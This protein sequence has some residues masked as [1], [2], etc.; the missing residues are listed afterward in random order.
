MI[1]IADCEGD[2]CRRYD[3]G[4]K[5]KQKL[6]MDG[7]GQQQYYYHQTIFS[8]EC[9]VT[10]ISYLIDSIPLY[11]NTKAIETIDKQY[12]NRLHFSSNFYNHDHQPLILIE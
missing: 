4:E 11:G 9:I 6:D 10:I 3:R 7:S 5:N 8:I 12:I 2:A 1:E